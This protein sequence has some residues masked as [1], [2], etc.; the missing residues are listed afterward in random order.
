MFK[1]PNFLCLQTFM[2]SL[3]RS[4]EH[5]RTNLKV[6]QT[7]TYTCTNPEQLEQLA[8]KLDSL[9]MEFHAVL[10]QREG[11]TL[12]PQACFAARKKAQKI[13]HKY[14]NLPLR[15]KRGCPK[16]DWRYRNRVGQ[17]AE[18]FRKVHFK[19]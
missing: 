11:L 14:L 6:L 7:L 5:A 10:P 15:L 2:T 16:S 8:T 13:K 4:G 17:K 9:I 19:I 12:R 18:S 3:K 1:S